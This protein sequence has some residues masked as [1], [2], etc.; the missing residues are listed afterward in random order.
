MD[1]QVPSPRTTLAILLGASTWPD[2]PDFPGSQA[3]ANAAA[4]FRKYL[5]APDL[6]G[7]PKENA[8][9]LFDVDDSPL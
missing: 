1:N 3:F 8:L 6:F 7:L 5:F 4:G 2:S 9:D